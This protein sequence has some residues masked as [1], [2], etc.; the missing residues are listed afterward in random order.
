VCGNLKK[1]NKKRAEDGRER[2]RE[3][4]KASRA[5]S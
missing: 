2:E 4:K 3:K 1:I 5:L